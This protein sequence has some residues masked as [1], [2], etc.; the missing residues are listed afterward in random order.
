[1]IPRGPRSILDQH[2]GFGTDSGC[3]AM[4]VLVPQ[5]FVGSSSRLGQLDV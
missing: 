5:E 1:M 4:K 3:G 2:L